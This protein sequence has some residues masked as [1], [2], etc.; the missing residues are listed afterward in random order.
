MELPRAWQAAPLHNVQLEFNAAHAAQPVV[1]STGGGAGEPDA[2]AAA[3]ERAAML[4]TRLAFKATTLMVFDKKTKERLSEWRG[5]QGENAAAQSA[6]AAS[7]RAPAAKA[8]TCGAGA[9]GASWKPPSLG[10]S[11]GDASEGGA[12]AR[13]PPGKART[14]M[15]RFTQ[16]RRSFRVVDA[17]GGGSPR[18][19]AARGAPGLGLEEADLQLPTMPPLAPHAAPAQP[20]HAAMHASHAHALPAAGAGEA[21]VQ[22]AAGLDGFVGREAFAQRR[23]AALRQAQ[24]RKKEAAFGR[25]LARR[26]RALAA[27]RARLAQVELVRSAEARAEV[28][29]AAALPPA[30]PLA[31]AAARAAEEALRAKQ[32]D[33]DAKRRSRDEAVRYISALQH[34]LENMVHSKSGFKLP[35]LCQCQAAAAAAAAAAHAAQR[36]V[37]PSS[38]FMVDP[39]SPAASTAAAAPSASLGAPWEHCANNCR[40]YKNPQAYAKELADLF[41]SLDL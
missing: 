21:E 32:A 29:R 23:E 12:G 7:A 5:R 17:P 19:V 40:F 11:H 41:K 33:A 4:E 36:P 25:L 27:D 3:R 15:L 24:V 28:A 35:A 10:V 9:L 26:Q 6:L 14:Q 16:G 30:A 37:N 18:A 2:A 1:I 20:S 13:S 34:R 8:S 22:E 38:L 39:F 31:E